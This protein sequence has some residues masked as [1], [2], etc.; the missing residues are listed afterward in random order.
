MSTWSSIAFAEEKRRVEHAAPRD[1]DKFAVFLRGATSEP[2]PKAQNVA[3]SL[4]YIDEIRQLDEKVP[5]AREVFLRELPVEVC[6]SD[7]PVAFARTTRR[8]SFVSGCKAHR[9]RRLRCESD[10]M[11]GF[12]QPEAVHFMKNESKEL[13]GKAP[14]RPQ[15]LSS[16]RATSASACTKRRLASWLLLLKMRKAGTLFTT[17]R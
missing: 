8:R 6:G 1:V 7:S 9:E 10:G 4:L 13:T 14:N 3:P 2:P 11:A 5:S 17:R 15:R 12:G 16:C